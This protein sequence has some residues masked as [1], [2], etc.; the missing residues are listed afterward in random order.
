[1]DEEEIVLAGGLATK[2]TRVGDVVYRSSKPQSNTVLSLLS[3]LANA[4]FPASP[5]PIGDGF[6][7][8]GREMLK[9]IDGASPQPL[10]WS[11]EAVYE[12]GE[13]LRQLHDVTSQWTPPPDAYWRPWFIREMKGE[14]TVIG[15]GDLGPWNILARD[16]HPVA[17]IDWDNAGP[18]DPLWELAHLAW[19]NAQLYDDDVAE[20]NRLP[21]ATQRALQA[22]LIL[23]GYGLEHSE[24]LGFVD[25]MIQLAIWSAR[26]EA[27]EFN[28]Q[29][30]CPWP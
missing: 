3:F 26:E 9:F 13:M 5:Q 28:V 22:R 17:F 19:Q 25:R 24:R 4:G 20:L 15:H 16:G 23:D 29:A 14:R 2:V 21:D 27:I 8:D 1:M 10:A 12:I 7:T 6:A 11:N 30:N 18:L